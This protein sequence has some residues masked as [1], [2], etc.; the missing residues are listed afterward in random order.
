M[1]VNRKKKVCKYRGSQ[2]HGGGAM[3]K[4]R[5]AGHRGGR[6]NAG[7]GKRGDARKPSYNIKKYFGR[8]KTVSKPNKQPAAAINFYQIEQKIYDFV[9]EGYAKENKGVIELD[10]TKAGYDKLLGTGQLVNKYN[11]TVKYASRKAIQKIEENGGVLNLATAPDTDN[12]E[13][14]K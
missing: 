12:V 11:I 13:A 7:S 6:G 14:V 1:T 9:A 2:T 8:H 3:K 4:R 5:G 10:L